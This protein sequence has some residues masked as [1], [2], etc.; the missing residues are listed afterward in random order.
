[1]RCN[2]TNVFFFFRKVAQITGPLLT[3]FGFL[4]PFHVRGGRGG[5]VVKISQEFVL[6][7]LHLKHA[8]FLYYQMVS[9]QTLSYFTE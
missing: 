4:H 5:G 7:L 2:K 1:M 9:P 3:D 6:A 8:V